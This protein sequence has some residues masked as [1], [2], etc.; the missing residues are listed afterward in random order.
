MNFRDKAHTWMLLRAVDCRIAA[1]RSQF[2]LNPSFDGIVSVLLSGLGFTPTKES[3][4]KVLQH[5]HPDSCS[6][7]HQME[8]R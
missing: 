8:G 3:V 7:P 1:R 5:I 2:V 4:R 6:C